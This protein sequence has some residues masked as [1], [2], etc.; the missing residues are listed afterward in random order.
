MTCP[1]NAL[2]FSRFI[3]AP[4]RAAASLIRH[5]HQHRTRPTLL[6][7]NSLTLR[8]VLV[9]QTFENPFQKRSLRLRCILFPSTR[10][11][12]FCLHKSERR[13]DH[14]H[15]RAHQ[16][17]PHPL[18]IPDRLAESRSDRVPTPLG[19]G[20]LALNSLAALSISPKTRPISTAIRMEEQPSSP[21][22][23]PNIDPTYKNIHVSYLDEEREPNIDAVPSS[24]LYPQPRPFPL[25]HLQLHP[26]LQQPRPAVADISDD[27]YP[28]RSSSRL[29]RSRA[30]SRPRSPET[31]AGSN[32]PARPH[33]SASVSATTNDSARHR[34]AYTHNA[35]ERVKSA[36]LACPCPY[37][38]VGS[39]STT[40]T[41]T[42][43]SSSN[44]RRTPPRPA[45]SSSTL[46]TSTAPPPFGSSTTG[47]QSSE[48]RLPT[49][50]PSASPASPPIPIPGLG[51]SPSEPVTPERSNYFATLYP[52]DYPGYKSPPRSLRSL[53]K[54]LAGVTD[55]QE[56]LAE[57]SGYTRD[58]YSAYSQPGS[59]KSSMS[60]SQLKRKV[61]IMGAPS[62][63]E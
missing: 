2:R 57:G 5:P 17:T 27:L 3:P 8:T 6:S 28:H 13:D 22:F 50:L 4:Q 42:R 33:R 53:P 49:V 48:H 11:I 44:R 61:V 16:C 37:G 7:L 31:R 52:A 15:T 39:S 25:P 46:T 63:G 19:S 26:L 1:T 9:Y 59:R 36:D 47:R 12:P 58:S 30:S 23:H 60:A 32:P 51:L 20:P 29:S 24:L 35:L 21:P 56:I 55:D 62:V 10:S 43:T 45:S 38:V 14:T 18:G 41:V 34:T 40:V 54:Q